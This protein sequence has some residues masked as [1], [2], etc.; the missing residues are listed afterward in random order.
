[1]AIIK[2]ILIFKKYTRDINVLS[3]YNKTKFHYMLK[4]LEASSS[5]NSKMSDQ[6][7]IG[8]STEFLGQN[9][10]RISVLKTK[11]C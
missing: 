4:I 1:M 11:T 6:I 8:N 5:V 9:Y 3:R 7:S 10:K 2:S